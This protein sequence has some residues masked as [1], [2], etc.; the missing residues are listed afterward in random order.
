VT[1][2]RLSPNGPTQG[3]EDSDPP[4]VFLPAALELDR[5][6]IAF[7]ELREQGPD[8]TFG[9]SDQPKVSP[10]LRRSFSRPLVLNQD[11]RPESAREAIASGQ[12]DAISFGRPFISNPDL[13][14]RLRT[15]AP[16]KADDMATWYSQGPEGYTDYQ[17]LDQP[18]AAE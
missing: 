12:A 8:G 7:L 14:E 4:S 16:L 10:L 5:I 9:S 15:G 11:Y 3:V 18:L 13:V 17:V 2:V 6:G 1:S